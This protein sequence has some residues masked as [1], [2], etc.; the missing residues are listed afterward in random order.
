M[1]DW[2]PSDSSIQELLYPNMTCFG[3]GPANSKGLRLRSF[4]VEDGVIAVFLPGPEHDNGLGFLNG[5]IICTVLDC[6][7][8]A[9]VASVAEQRSWTSQAGTA[10]VTAGLEVAFRRPT[11]LDVH[12]DLRA[13]V[14]MA[15]QGEM[16][17]EAELTWDGKV[18]AD[19]RSVWRASRAR[20]GQ[21]KLT[22]AE[23]TST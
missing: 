8:A 23:R 5:G 10:Y 4:A 9:A 2:S 3:C 16:H 15:S 20:P 21:S 22:V 19:A 1:A 13:R 17:V 7:S 18:R 12:L 11:P 14:T 6:H